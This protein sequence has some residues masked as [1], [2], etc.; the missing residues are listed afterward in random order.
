LRRSV[1]VQCA[2]CAHPSALAH[3]HLL[4]LCC[5]GAGSLAAPPPQGH[6]A[7]RLRGSAQAVTCASTGDMRSLREA[8]CHDGESHNRSTP[9]WAI[10]LPK[11]LR[12]RGRGASGVAASGRI[13]MESGHDEG[14][15]EDTE[16][17]TGMAASGWLYQ[18]P[19]SAIHAAGTGPRRTARSHRWRTAGKTGCPHGTFRLC[20]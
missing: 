10:V 11:R 16:L 18:L 7:W 3:R 14:R 15:A 2:L 17:A 13:E 12:V 5:S 19:W 4:S 9:L 20:L 1:I 8:L 6:A